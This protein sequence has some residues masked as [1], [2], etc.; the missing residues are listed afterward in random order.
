MHEHRQPQ[1]VPHFSATFALLWL[2]VGQ[3]NVA[4]TFYVLPYPCVLNFL[5]CALVVSS[6]VS[7]MP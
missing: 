6:N 3:G 2:G 1:G 7:D 5:C 4:R